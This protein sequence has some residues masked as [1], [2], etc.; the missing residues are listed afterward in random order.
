MKYTIDEENKLITIHSLDKKE[1]VEDLVF[2]LGDFPGFRV[3]LGSDEERYYRMEYT[4]PSST[5]TLPEGTNTDTK[6]ECDC[7]RNGAI[8]SC[9]LSN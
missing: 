1:Y 3:K 9:E 4:E 6:R 5:S 2:C 8:C 7:G